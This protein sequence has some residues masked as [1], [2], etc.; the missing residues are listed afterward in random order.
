MSDVTASVTDGCGDSDHRLKH[1]FHPTQR[2]QRNVHFP[3]NGRWRHKENTPA[4]NGRSGR[5]RRNGKNAS[6][7]VVTAGTGKQLPALIL[8]RSE[9]CRKILSSENLRSKMQTLGLKPPFCENL[10]RKL[11]F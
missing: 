5:K 2:T 4:R 7:G 9:N 3:R 11:K 10:R 8:G 1:R 6:N